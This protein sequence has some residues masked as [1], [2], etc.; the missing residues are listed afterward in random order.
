MSD[1]KQFKAIAIAFTRESLRNKLEVFFTL[2]FPLIFLILF[3]FFFGNNMSGEY[4]PEK[5]GIYSEIEQTEDIKAAL[6][7]SGAW[8]ITLYS[9]REDLAKAVENDGLLAGVSVA[10][11]KVTYIYQEGDISKTGQVEMARGAISSVISKTV[12]NVEDVFAVK[13][14]R[15]TAG[16]VIASNFDYLMTG[17]ISISILSAGMFS[18]ITLFGRYQDN[19]VLR[20]MSVA[21]I[22]P[23]I[24]ILGSTLTRFIISFMSVMLVILV[25]NLMFDINFTFDWPAFILVV[26]TS[27]L[28]MM[29]LGMFLLIV[30]K[31]P[32]TAETAGSILMTLMMFLSGIYVPIQFLPKSMQVV[33]LIFPVKYVADLVRSSAG[34]ISISNFNFWLINII[35]ALSG[36]IFLTITSN[37][38]LKSV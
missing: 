2:F 26:I 3:G 21:P 38:Y 9:S 16:T 37:K 12:N 24:F 15:E 7:D 6:E 27:T 4:N 33:A 25:S 35:F 5:I 28:A 19:G 20:K 11:G 36:I 18:M 8:V 1:F 23:L 30:F 13:K 14:I 29:A 10:D 31:K 17:I 22:K 34:L 32:Q